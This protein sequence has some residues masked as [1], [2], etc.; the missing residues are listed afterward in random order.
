MSCGEDGVC[1]HNFHRRCVAIQSQVWRILG[2]SVCFCFIMLF[3]N[4]N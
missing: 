1:V 2:V 3:Q 4:V